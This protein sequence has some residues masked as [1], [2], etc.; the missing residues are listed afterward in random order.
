LYISDEQM[1]KIND[2]GGGID[3]DGLAAQEAAP[4]G[5]TNE[6]SE[7]L[8]PAGGSPGSHAS[9]ETETTANLTNGNEEVPM[10]VFSEWAQKQISRASHN[11][12]L[13]VEVQSM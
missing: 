13:T 12:R 6:T 2:P 4:V 9:N 5:E 7:E 8:Q 11:T 1:P 3:L 10:P